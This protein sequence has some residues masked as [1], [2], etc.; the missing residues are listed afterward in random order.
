M[1][2]VVPNITRT[3]QVPPGALFYHLDAGGALCMA[4]SVSPDAD[5]SDEALIHYPSDPQSLGVPIYERNFRSAVVVLEGYAAQADLS[6]PVHAGEGVVL[7]DGKSLYLPL[8]NGRRF[9]TG[10]LD[11]ATGLI[12]S[13]VASSSIGFGGWSIVDIEDR[14]KVLWESGEVV[15][16]EG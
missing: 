13:N 5:E 12:Q 15:G 11:L 4:A 14:E 2:V 16:D 9:R 6:T 7:A 1:K 8:H 10:F 3:S